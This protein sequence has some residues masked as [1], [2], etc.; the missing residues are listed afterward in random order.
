MFK[1]LLSDFEPKRFVVVDLIP[2][3]SA[4]FYLDDVGIIL[5]K[6]PDRSDFLAAVG[7]NY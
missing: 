4:W 7:H 6:I 1:C 5:G 3:L 2:N